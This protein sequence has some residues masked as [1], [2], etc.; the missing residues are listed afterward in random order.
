MHPLFGSAPHVLLKAATQGGGVARNRLPML[1]LLLLATGLRWPLSLTEQAVQASKLARA[2]GQ[3][4]PV[5]IIGHWRS[6]TTH[7]Y[8]TLSQGDF[9]YVTPIA[10]GLPWDQAG[11]AAGLKPLLERML[12][13]RRFID[14]IPV[15]PQSPQE[16]EVPLAN[17]T[18]L[19]LYHA[20]YFPQR[21][22][23]TFRRA[24]FFEG[25]EP[26]EIEAWEA[27]LDY[28]LRKVWLQQ[29]RKQLLIKNP[30]YTGRIDRLKTLYPE[31]KF[32]HTVRNPFEVF[33][34]MR[35]F[36]AKLLPRFA[37][38]NYDHIDIDDFILKTHTRMMRDYRTACAKIPAGDLVEVR[39]DTLEADPM[40]TMRQVYETL[41]LPGF[42]E[43]EPRFAAYLKSVD[44]Y[45]KNRF[46]LDARTIARVSE[47][48]A[49]SID[50]WNFSTPQPRTA[51]AAA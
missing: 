50:H 8:N 43:T 37:L 31:A 38:A 49:D 12:P 1:A 21:F 44:G 34:S 18:T 45:R 17:M 9:G 5:F 10:A 40:G 41:S 29:G 19:S 42:A 35:N 24:V 32:I 3:I 30:A 25:A 26:A 2:R 20:L 36:Y 11:L 23:A 7:L 15:T 48:C 6:G 51:E 22:E 28:F 47:A 33:V 46:T 13:K 39:Y 4:Q 14:N 16:D 27:A